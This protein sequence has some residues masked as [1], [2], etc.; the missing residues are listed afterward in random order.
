MKLLLDEDLDVKLRHRFGPLHEVATVRQME[1]LGKKNGELLALMQVS[2]FEV[3]ITGDKNIGYQ[4][5]WHR[6]PLPVIQLDAV[7]KT[8]A[9]LLA[10]V[11]QVLALL[12]QPALPGGV[13]V[14]RPA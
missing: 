5:N 9:N 4:Q 12:A 6:Y 2:G 3:L 10:L 14:L 8:Y 11:P 1:W 13:H 7:P